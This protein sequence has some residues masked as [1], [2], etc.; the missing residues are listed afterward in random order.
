MLQNDANKKI[1]KFRK[2]MGD[3]YFHAQYYRSIWQETGSHG[4]ERTRVGRWS[5]DSVRCALLSS[6]LAHAHASV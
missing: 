3:I 1:I 6:G 2:E 5:Q 4:G